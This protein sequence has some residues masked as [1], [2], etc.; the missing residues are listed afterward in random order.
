M[1]AGPRADAKESAVLDVLCVAGV[2][3]LGAIVALVGRAVERL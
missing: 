2:L 3:A 1:P